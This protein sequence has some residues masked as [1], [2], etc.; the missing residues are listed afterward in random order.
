MFHRAQLLSVLLASTALCRSLG[1][2]QGPSSSL[3]ERSLP[4]FDE[5][6]YSLLEVKTRVDQARRR[7]PPTPGADPALLGLKEADNGNP[8]P[9]ENGGGKETGSQEEDQKDV[10]KEQDN[11]KD[12]GKEKEDEK[13]KGKDA[14]KAETRT[15]TATRKRK[16]KKKL[17]AAE[18]KLE[19]LKSGGSS[20]REAKLDPKE[21]GPDE[22]PNA[23]GQKSG[24]DPKDTVT[25]P[26]KDATPPPTKDNTPAPV[27]PPTTPPATLP[28]KPDDPGH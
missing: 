18:E 13:D 14:N 7:P 5:A 19:L 24:L 3:H 20:K 23:N 1:Q 12:V 9:K 16:R 15:R 2:F 27:T 28:T 26:I 8:P 6:N 21:L 10:G 25:P 22:D 17:A 11:P 4:S